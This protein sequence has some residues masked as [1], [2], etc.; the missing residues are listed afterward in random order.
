MQ[1]SGEIAAVGT[2]VCWACAASFFVSAGRRM[3]SMQLNRTRLLVAGVLL[4]VTLWV[5]R[6]SP[7]PSWATREQS[8]YLAVS[9]LLG[10]AF[11]DSLYF[12]ALVILG[13]GRAA[14]LLSLAPIFAALFA[15]VFLGEVLGPRAVLGM[16]VTWSGLGLVLYRRARASGDH[17]EGSVRR[18]IVCGVLASIGAG[19]GYVLS[20]RGLEGGLDA[21]SGTFIRVVAAAAV[22][23]LAALVQRRSRERRGAI[24][25]IAIGSMIAGA[26]FGP[27]LGVGLSLFALQHAPTAVA[28][29]IFACSPL[30]AIVLGAKFHGE[31]L[32]PRV[33]AGALLAVAGVVLMFSRHL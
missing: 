24:D 5:L 16:L 28:C 8:A 22:L 3:G 4:A 9:G 13:A 32:D 26:F 29:S 23:W 25:R 31:Q 19:A 6:G 14:L 1:A 10:F 33:A 27:F 17:P 18:G 20:K 7:W 15:R 30:L 2:A 11:G 12:R 21:I